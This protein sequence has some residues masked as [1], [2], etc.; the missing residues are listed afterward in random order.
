MQSSSQ[1]LSNACSKSYA[2]KKSG[3][4]MNLKWS[5]HPRRRKILSD[6]VIQDTVIQDSR[7]V[8]HPYQRAM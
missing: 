6:T 3:F 5:M 1:R 2:V 8:E 7:K 4:F